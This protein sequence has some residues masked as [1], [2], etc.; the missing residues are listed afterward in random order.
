LWSELKWTPVNSDTQDLSTSVFVY[1]AA[2]LLLRARNGADGW[3]SFVLLGGVLGLAYLSKTAL[4]LVSPAFLAAALFSAVS[5]RRALPRVIVAGAALAVVALPFAGAISAKEGRLTLGDTGKYVY[6]LFVN[7]SFPTVPF[8]H[9]QGEPPEF[10]TPLHPTRKIHESPET[11]EFATPVAGSYP[12]WYNP[13]YWYAGL[14]IRLDLQQ[15]LRVLAS[16]LFFVWTTFVGALAFGYLALI[17]GGD[18]LRPSLAA[19]RENAAVLIP[20]VTGL[21]VYLVAT[22]LQRS[23]IPTQ[24]AMRYISPFAVLLF[25]GIFSSVRLPESGES[26]R[27]LQGVMFPAWVIVGASLIAGLVQH[28]L[29]G[30]RYRDHVDWQIAENLTSLGVRPGDTIAHLGKEETLYWTRLAGVRII[31]EIPDQ[32][33]FWIETAPARAGALQMIE[34]TGAKAVVST[35]LGGALYATAEG[36]QRLDSGRYVY[37]FDRD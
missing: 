23:E 29:S 2:G 18:R 3:L 15:Q 10:G 17:R 34:R 9:W 14:K 35:S 8:V 24:P 36:W 5:V 32:T 1:L 13:S 16:N 37:L 28:R 30:S 12:P 31:A 7:P 27:W 22:D 26:M 11:F 21:A 6:V 20:A 33:A 25:A 19:L 4:L